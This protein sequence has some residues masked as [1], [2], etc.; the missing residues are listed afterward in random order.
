MNIYRRASVIVGSRERGGPEMLPADVAAIE[1]GL[2]TAKAIAD[3]EG[4]R[5]IWVVTN[6][7][8]PA[9]LDRHQ[10]VSGAFGEATARLL[11][12][13][14]AV[15]WQGMTLR[16]ASARTLTTSESVLALYPKAALLAQLD[17]L[18]QPNAVVVVP[19]LDEDVRAW[20][21][22][23]GPVD[24]FNGDERVQR[25]A[26]SDQDVREAVDTLTSTMTGLGHP[27]D[28]RRARDVFARMR[29][30]HRVDPNEIRAHVVRE[31]GWSTSQ[32]DTLAKIAAGRA[33][34]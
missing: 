30:S 4:W 29:R 11:R 23:W 12:A 24:I 13:G 2:R 21:E 22:A 20:I 16:H 34:R 25:L 8:Q 15:P 14:H 19:F 7:A 26:I 5:T 18:M 27:S 33:R 32:A 17:D 3:N 28:E 6:T 10:A 31:T 1:L 9:D